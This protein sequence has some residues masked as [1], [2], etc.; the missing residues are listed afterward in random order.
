MRVLV[1][2][3]L[4]DAERTAARLTAMGHDPM[5]VPLLSI[6][7]AATPPPDGRADALLVTSA[8]AA[9]ALAQ[10]DRKDLCVFTVG[11]RSAAAVRAAGFDHVCQGGGDAAGLA[12]LVAK[13]L[14][15]G[16]ALLHVA[17]THRKSEPE[18]SLRAAGYAIRVWEAYEAK[19]AAVLPAALSF[20]LTAGRIDGALHYSRRSAALLVELV[21]R[22]GLLASLRSVTHACLSADVAVPLSRLDADVRVAAEPHE[23]ALLA[24]LD[25]FAPVKGSRRPAS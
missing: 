17:G 3:P 15:S 12:S 20:A 2:R 11:E 18:E 7:V 9:A 25:P 23:T 21:E 24:V 19:A 16:S 1:T 4:E 14:P 22:A 13:N 8:H 6:T 10:L 5:L